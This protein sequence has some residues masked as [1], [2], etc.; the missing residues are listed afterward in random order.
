MDTYIHVSF[1]IVKIEA[2]NKVIFV[3]ELFDH[4]INKIDH[5]ASKD[6][7]NKMNDRNLKSDF[8]YTFKLRIGTALANLNVPLFGLFIHSRYHIDRKII[9]FG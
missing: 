8:Q 1:L 3:F 4:L 6:K 9:F 5:Q 7:H 2:D